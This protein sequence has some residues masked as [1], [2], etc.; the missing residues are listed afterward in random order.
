MRDFQ[1][2]P[3]AIEH[4]Q[5]QIVQSFSPIISSS[6]ILFHSSSNFFSPST[7]FLIPFFHPLRSLSLSPKTSKLRYFFSTLFLEISKEKITFILY[8]NFLFYI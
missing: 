2:T 3:H 5:H 1:I 6:L 4:A 7:P 8:R